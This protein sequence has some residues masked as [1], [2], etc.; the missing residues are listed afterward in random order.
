MWIFPTSTA[1]ELVAI[2]LADKLNLERV[3][4]VTNSFDT[5]MN[6]NLLIASYGS[7]HY[8]HRLTGEN[9]SLFLP[10]AQR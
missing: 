5:V 3:G 6:G 8:I 2:N 10:T 7:A 9:D 4:R 1:L